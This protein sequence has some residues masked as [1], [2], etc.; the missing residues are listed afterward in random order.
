MQSASLQAIFTADTTNFDRGV[1]NVKRSMTGVANDISKDLKKVGSDISGFGRQLTG[2]GA[3]IVAGFGLAIKASIDFDEQ[4]TNIASVMGYTRA[5]SDAM[6]QALMGMS[7]DS[8]FSATELAGAMYDVVGGVADASMHMEIL[9]AA[10]ALAEAN[11]AELDGSTS[12]LIATMNAFRNANVDATHVSDVMTQTIKDGVGTM[13]ELAAVFGRTSTLASPLGIDIE[14]LG[15]LFAELS[16]NGATFSQSGTYIEGALSALINPTKELQDAFKQ[17]GMSQS[18][19]LKMLEDEGL[20]AVIKKMV[21]AGVDLTAVFNNKEALLGVLSIANLESDGLAEFVTNAEGATEATRQI[22]AEA[23]KF[24]LDT[25][26]GD[27]S[28]MAVVV[29]DALTPG[30]S[31]LF[32]RLSPVVQDFAEWAK[33]NPETI[34][35]IAQLAIGVSALGLI[36]MPLGTILGVVGTALGVVSTGL[37]TIVTI[38][39]GVRGALGGILAAALPIAGPFL[40]AAAAV[41]GLI[42]A[43][44]KLHEGK[45]RGNLGGY[46]TIEERNAAAINLGKQIVPLQVGSQTP[47]TP[48][49]SE[50][51]TNTSNNPL[52]NSNPFTNITPQLPGETSMGG[53]RAWGGDV[54]AGVPYKI[55]ETGKPETVIFP[56][57]GFVVSNPSTYGG[58]NYGGRIM[59][60]GGLQI[61]GGVYNFY[62]V[63][64]IDQLY[65]QLVQIEG[66]RS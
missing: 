10:S 29:G 39:A 32:T 45:H 44:E 60:G 50:A 9:A 12:A 42:F 7:R 18:D 34:S 52:L 16:K 61:V 15:Y 33:D 53:G 14:E 11:N 1:N 25:L 27:M 47:F 56:A 26:V 8:K 23:D 20:V 4:L 49:L 2:F 21:D 62:G 43:L 35:T 37:T 51:I 6:G 57:N 58:N 30:L 28:D 48:V 38:T 24:K 17:M 46:N 3:P 19:V 65:D 22:A 36:L 66:Q 59:G 64:D 63:Q 41:T 54:M 31:D 5:E 13:D 40:A 55:N